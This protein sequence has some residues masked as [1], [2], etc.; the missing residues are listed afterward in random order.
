M[1]RAAAESLTTSF[2][3]AAGMG[4][5]AVALLVATVVSGARDAGAAAV[6]RTK[7]P[8][9]PEAPALKLPKVQSQTLA[10]GLEL[11]VVEMHEVPV[12]D[13]T[14]ILGAG[15]VRDPGDLPGLATFVA[16]MLDE[17]AGGRDALGLADEV[18]F[19][20]ASLSSAAGAEHATV[21]LHA[22]K[23]RLEPALGL[24][25][26][27]VLRPAFADSEITRQRELRSN[28][29]LQL[30]DQPTAMA[31]IAFD[32]IVF[33]AAHPYGR[34]IG[35]TE[36]ST[37][38]LDRARVTGFYQQYYRPN[39][40]K[41]LVVGDIT[42]AEAKK[43]VTAR[44]GEWAKGDVSPLPEAKAPAPGPR[45]FYIVDKPGAAQ[46]VIRMGHPGVA[47]STPDYHA[48]QVLNTILGGSFT[49]RLN[50]N[51]RETKGYTYGAGSR[52]DMRR[53]AGPFFATASVVSDK[54]DSSLVEFFKEIRTIRDHPVPAV[55]LE[56]AKAYL[57][58]GLPGEFE[59]TSGAAGQYLDLLAHNLP[60]DTYDTSIPGIRKVTA[61]D[62]QRAAKTYI[63]PD[64]LA[65]IIVGD[66]KI[67]EAGV[68]GLSEGP[69]VVRD[70]W[71]K[72]LP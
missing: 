26:D 60:L 4:A 24:M 55:E 38:L 16:N 61:A 27:V 34:P 12:V 50:N 13:V 22:L 51:L 48:L 42:P 3:H 71:G 33:G 70:L 59:T 29:L 65:V 37:A 21:R 10:N 11:Y 58:L 8:P 19:L 17:G 52:F 39:A 31:P 54:T 43:L 25:A 36:E 53:M 7:A 64:H 44:F 30:R 69:V 14:L 72:P 46:S 35:G 41:M 57:A 40:S 32:A 49:S 15:A 2:R 23:R 63:D 5:I 6:D 47:R 20:G 62:V 18:A 9:S 45:T 68:A 1:S 67:I 56:K 66:R 28:A